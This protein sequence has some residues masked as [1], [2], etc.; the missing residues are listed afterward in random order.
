MDIEDVR[1]C[2]IPENALHT[3]RRAPS[4][5]VDRPSCGFDIAVHFRYIL[6]CTRSS[7]GR[8]EVHLHT[9][10]IEALGEVHRRGRDGNVNEPR[11]GNDTRDNFI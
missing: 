7:G 2:G 11:S 3:M 10:S 9:V 1:S 5:I 6:D 8:W 4:S